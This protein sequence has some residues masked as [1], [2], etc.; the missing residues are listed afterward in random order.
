MKLSNR[1]VNEDETKFTITVIMKN[2]WIPHFLSMLKY[3][4]QLG[5]AGSSRVV[6]FFADGDGDFHPRFEWDDDL[7]CDVK[8]AKEDDGDRFYDA[9]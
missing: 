1:E 7:P 2:R 3:M 5:S 6:S 9:G 4:Q 8:P